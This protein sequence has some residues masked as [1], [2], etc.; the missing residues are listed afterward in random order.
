MTA[1]LDAPRPLAFAHRG[2][3]RDGLENTMV[4][5]QAAVDLGFTHLE[6]DVHATRDGRLVAFHDDHLDRVTDGAGAVRDLA[7]DVVRR[8]RVGG[9]QAI[10]LLEDVLGAWPD[11]RVNVDVKRPAAVAPLVDVIERTAAH[12]RV[13]VASFSDRRRQAVLRRLSR[14]VATSA[15]GGTVGRLLA[16]LRSGAPGAVV[17]R[18][19]RGVDCVQVPERVA[20]PVPG[21]RRVLTVVTPR[22]LGAAHRAGVQVHVWTVDQAD[23]MHRLLDAGVD[24]LMTDRAD[25]LRVV[26]DD[27]ADRQT[28]RRT[29]RQAGRRAD[30]RGGRTA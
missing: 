7:W 21:G 13:C 19:L 14:P 17:D 5:F 22:L 23:D 25:R 8:A 2:F 3:S 9:V 12:D 24:G 20:V 16:A 6:T 28:D 10:P 26:L 11:V 18:V 30:R 27:R 29:D 15:G 1:F 4:A